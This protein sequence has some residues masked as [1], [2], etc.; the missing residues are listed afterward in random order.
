MLEHFD[1]RTHTR[2]LA[3]AWQTLSKGEGGEECWFRGLK[4]GCSDAKPLR[5]SRKYGIILTERKESGQEGKE[6][7]IASTLALPCDKAMILRTIRMM[8]GNNL[9]IK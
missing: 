8:V 2:V 5:Y 9:K 6:E 4:C 3:V 7:K 1:S